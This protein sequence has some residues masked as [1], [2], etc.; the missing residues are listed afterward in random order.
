MCTGQIVKQSFTLKLRPNRSNFFATVFFF[1]FYR[2]FIQI[3]WK[4]RVGQKKQLK[5]DL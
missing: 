4:N 5:C 2:C 3:I 1:S